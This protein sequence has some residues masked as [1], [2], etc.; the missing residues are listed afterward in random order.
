MRQTTASSTP[1]RGPDP[2]TAHGALWPDTLPMADDPLALPDTGPFREALE[3]LQVRELPD[4]SLFQRL[5]GP[6]P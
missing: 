1:L 3:G 6:H 2:I 4:L 5:F